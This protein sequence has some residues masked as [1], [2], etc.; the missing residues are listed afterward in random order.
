M[1]PHPSWSPNHRST[2]LATVSALEPIQSF[3]KN[4]VPLLDFYLVYLS[5][6]RAYHLS[7][8]ILLAKLTSK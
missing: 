3:G 6:C 4:A 5:R 2:D 1:A 7:F 8:D